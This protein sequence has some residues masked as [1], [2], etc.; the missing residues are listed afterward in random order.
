MAYFRC[1]KKAPIVVRGTA[2]KTTTASTKV[3]LGFR[4]TFV[5]YYNITNANAVHSI[6]MWDSN[7]PNY[8]VYSYNNQVSLPMPSTNANILASIDADGFTVNKSSSL[9]LSA[10]IEYIAIKE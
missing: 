5:M 1:E 6:V 3:T 10:T 8:Q 7:R 9:A 4:P 2:K